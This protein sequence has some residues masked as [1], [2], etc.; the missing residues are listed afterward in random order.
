M[1][2]HREERIPHIN[3]GTCKHITTNAQRPTLNAKRTTNLT[4]SIG[5]LIN[6]QMIMKESSL[7]SLIGD[8]IQGKCKWSSFI[9]GKNGFFYGIP[10]CARR[11]VK[12][13]PLDKSLTPIGPDLGSRG[14]KW[15][16]GVRDTRGNIYC[17]PAYADHFL[18]IDTVR[19]AVEIL[20]GVAMPETGECLW[21]SGALAADNNI[22]YMPYNA[23]RIMKLNP[24][25][26][27]LSSVGDDL[28]EQGFKCRGTV[29]GSDNWV[30]SIPLNAT[31]IFKFDPANPD[32]TSTVGEEAEFGFECGGNGV[33]AGDGYIYAASDS[34]QV[35]QIDT[36][37]NNYTWIG[38]PIYS[39]G[40]GWGDPIIGADKC[41]YWPPFYA[42]RVLKFDPETQQLPSLVGDDLGEGYNKWQGGALATDG[43]IYC[44]PSSAKQILAIDPF[45]ELVMT[46]QNSIQKYPQ[47]LGRL[48][49]KDGCNE[50][51]FGSAV[52]KFGIEKVFEFLV[53]ECLPSDKEWAN[54]CSGHS[55]PLFMVAASCE[56]CSVSVIYHLLRRNVHDALSGNLNCVGVSKKRKV[57]ST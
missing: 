9:D 43:A 8:E 13:N 19:G 33:L 20:A 49:A 54:T 31:H 10:F 37:I 41:V 22:Y 52:R 53:E 21:E 42:N 27:S 32:T 3:H 36:T 6:Y 28:G 11:V 35:L 15:R 2:N 39:R 38:D 16:C 7:T 17:A 23:R 14:N 12:F 55:L 57:G 50:T 40:P 56:N 4:P 30:Y 24:D 44:I 48:F 18:K 34:G 29:V 45:K 51:F 46:M 26:D 1:A 5:T 47:E 25:N